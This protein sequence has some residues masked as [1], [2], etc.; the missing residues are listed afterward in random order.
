MSRELA[1]RVALVTGASRGIGRRT[2]LELGRRKARVAVV[3]RTE[4]ALTSLVAELRRDGVD[5]EAFPADVTDPAAR[6]K[7]VADVVK[8]FGKL[9][10]LVNSAGTASFAEFTDSTPEI[11]RAITEVNFFASVELIRAAHPELLKSSLAGRK[12][13]G[14]RAA[15]VNVASTCGRIGVPSMSEHCGSKHAI[16]GFTEAIRQEFAQFDIDVLIVHPSLVKTD[17]PAKHYIQNRGKV[18]LAFD[19]AVP[20]E[21]VAARLV[22]SLEQRKRETPVGF[23]AWWACFGKR[24]WPRLVRWMFRRKVR[25]YVAKHGE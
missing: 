6:A 21:E 11:L 17:D 18:H 10:V 22:N 13:D 9:D 5:C 20:P 23:D 14:W 1:G 8:R 2:A 16:T 3:A 15:I 7:L 19:K 24:A 12:S 25:K 4:P